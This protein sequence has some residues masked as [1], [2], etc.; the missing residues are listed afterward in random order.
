MR[1]IDL[2][3][4]IGGF[5]LGMETAGHECVGYCEIDKF[6]DRSYRAMHNVKES[7]WNAADIRAVEPGDL[8]DADCYCGGFPCQAF[9]IAGKR[10]GFEDTRGTLFF[11]VMRLAAV[12]KPKYLFMENVAGLLSHDG[13]KTFGTILNT[14]GELGYWYE[15][16]ML[17]SKDFGVPQNRKRVFIVGHLRGTSTREVFPIRESSG[18]HNR[19]G[20]DKEEIYEAALCLTAKGMSNWSGSFVYQ[21]T[22][23]CSVT[24]KQDETGTLQAARVDKVPC[25]EVRAVLTPDRIEKRQNG[26]RMKEPGEEMFTLTVRD[27]HGVELR[28][29][30]PSSDAQ[31]VYDS[32]GLARTLKSG[33][34]GQGGKTG[35][36]QVESNI[37]RLTPKECFRLQGFPDTYFERAATVNS[38]SQLYKQAGNCVTV[39][40]IYEIAKRLWEDNLM[41]TAWLQVKVLN[42]KSNKNHTLMQVATNAS[43]E[44]ILRYA[45]EKGLC[46]ELRLED[47]KR[48]TA[49]QRK[50]LYATFKDISD[51]SGN[52]PEYTKEFHKFLFCAETGQE[53]FSLSDCSMNTARE[54][55]NNVIEYVIENDIPLTELAIDRTD[56]IGKYLYMCIKYSRCC[57]CGLQGVTYTL[58]RERNKMCLCNTHYDMAK[59]RGLTEFEKAFKVYGIQ[60]LG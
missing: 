25:V 47:V 23:G 38:D 42:V 20:T 28:Q 59:A 11:E 39:N 10:G 36:Y 41:K 9:S 58:D 29:L 7:E 4:G 26:R 2:F 40:V 48:I 14:M 55:I 33:G 17:N 54:L 35:L 53:Y 22:H 34:G 13:G 8:P 57:I 24:V 44:E 27:K 32:D 46:G 37:R 5:R 51:Y 31:R 1:F 16:Q 15:Y 52:P 56:D 21:N 19:F 30:I 45:N 60:Y 50:K 6:A 3:S 18:I 43:K 12:R 49:E